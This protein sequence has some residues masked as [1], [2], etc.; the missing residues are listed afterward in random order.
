M[1]YMYDSDMDTD[2]ETNYDTESMSDSDSEYEYEEEYEY[3]PE[4]QSRTKNNIVICQAYQDMDIDGYELVHLRLKKFDYPQIHAMYRTI[5]CQRPACKL[6]IAECVYLPSGHCI[7]ILKTFWIRIIQR[8][9]KK[10]Y[11][12]RKQYFV[13]MMQKIMSREVFINWPRRIPGLKGLLCSLR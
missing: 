6:E 13:T 9:W 10:V 4:E 5:M 3:E 1:A 8:A 12:Q 2:T 11:K 7:A